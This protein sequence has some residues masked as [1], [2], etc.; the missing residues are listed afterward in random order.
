MKK[1][2]L[3]LLILVMALTAVLAS[4][5]SPE[6]QSEAWVESHL[7]Y[8]HDDVHDVGIWIIDARNKLGGRHIFILPDSEYSN[9]GKAW[10][11]K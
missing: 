9:P 11:E 8:V 5:C 4:G 10:P 1:V 6:P 7:R 2:G 3:V